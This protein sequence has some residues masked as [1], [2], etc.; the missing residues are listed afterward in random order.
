MYIKLDYYS[1]WNLNLSLNLTPPMKIVNMTSLPE[2]GVSHNPDIK[3][4]TLIGKGEIP[5]LMMFS[6]AVLKPGQ[7][8]ESHT[9]ETMYEVFFICSGR[10]VFTID[11]REI[12]AQEG[13]CITV[14]PK[15][16]H[17]LKNPF[18]ADGTW[19][20]FGIATDAT[21]PSST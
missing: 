21:S 6:K 15:E 11:G 1:I 2:T 13:D 5:R 17:S 3:R 19:L 20:Y 8:V 16:N 7:F 10:A 14:A 4:K 9:H 18:D 12:E